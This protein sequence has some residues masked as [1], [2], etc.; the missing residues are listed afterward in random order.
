MKNY[1][2]EQGKDTL[3]LSTPEYAVED[4]LKILELSGYRNV[5]VRE[6]IG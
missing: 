2:I 4:Y 3:V 6:L 5:E 1:R